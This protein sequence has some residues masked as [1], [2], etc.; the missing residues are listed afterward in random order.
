MKKVSKRSL[1]SFVKRYNDDLIEFQKKDLKE[2]IK[3]FWKDYKYSELPK[4][5]MICKHWLNTIVIPNI[6][7]E[8][9]GEVELIIEGVESFLNEI[10]I[11][12][13]TSLKIE[14]FKN[15]INIAVTTSKMSLGGKISTKAA[16]GQMIADQTEHIREKVEKETRS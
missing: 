5:D 6:V 1:D 9:E 14:D 15:R 3:G 10:P 2:S 8:H 16:V 11:L 7:R 4:F 13:L 12:K